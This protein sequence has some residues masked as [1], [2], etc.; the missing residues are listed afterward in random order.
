MKFNILTF[1]GTVVPIGAAIAVLTG[2]V[3]V[4]PSG[5]VG[6]VWYGFPRAWL[7]R[8]VIAPQ[9]YPW[10]VDG[11]SLALD[12]AFWCSLAAVIQLISVVLYEYSK[13]TRSSDATVITNPGATK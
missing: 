4:T 1:F 13:R 2:L 11:L 10:N 5:L 12:I 6:A 8:L 9:Y 7:H 3:N